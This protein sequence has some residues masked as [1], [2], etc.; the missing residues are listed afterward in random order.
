MS[1]KAIT[2]HDK[3]FMFKA[4]DTKVKVGIESFEAPPAKKGKA[5]P[6]KKDEGPAKKL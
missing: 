4:K 1:S 5:P 2:T 3:L 6:A